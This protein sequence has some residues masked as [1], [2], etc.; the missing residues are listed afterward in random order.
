MKEVKKEFFLKKSENM[1]LYKTRM[2][3]NTATKVRETLKTLLY[4]YTELENFKKN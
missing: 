4:L 3:S 1:Y 2:Y